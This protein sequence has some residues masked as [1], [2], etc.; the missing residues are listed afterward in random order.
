M[1]HAAFTAALPKV[2]LRLHLPGAP[3]GPATRAEVRERTSAHLRR[4]AAQ[5]VRHVEVSFDPRAHLARGVAFEDVVLGHHDAAVDAGR[6]LGLSAALVL[7]LGR[8][9]PLADAEAALEAA[10]GFREQV[11]GLGLGP[12]GREDPPARFAPLLARARAGGFRLAAE[13]DADPEVAAEHL[14]QL[15]ED[16][17]VDRL[18]PGPAAVADPRLPALVR[19]RGTGLTCSPLSN[20]LATG[21]SGAL[22]VAGLLRRGTA[23]AVTSGDPARTGGHLTEN[24]VTLTR[25]ADL[26]FDEL[27]QLQRNAVEISWATADVREGFLAELDAFEVLAA[28]DL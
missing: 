19:G 20:A 3:E 10:L 12:G 25:E 11:V 6:E 2:D 5:N 4:V 21:G 27:I 8:E 26:T 1:D 18:D 13:A 9:Q 7:H 14:R 15:V 28:P 23:V 24:L 22:A 16:L 17:G